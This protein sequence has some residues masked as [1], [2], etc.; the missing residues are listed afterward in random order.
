MLLLLAELL[1]LGLV[2]YGLWL[3]WEPAALVAVGVILV[4]AANLWPLRRR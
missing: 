4:V 3:I 2:A 1:G